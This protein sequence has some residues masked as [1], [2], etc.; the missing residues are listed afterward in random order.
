MD[1]GK[2]I[3]IDGQTNTQMEEKIEIKM[4][5]PMDGRTDRQIEG[6]PDGQT[7]T[8]T[9]IYLTHVYMILCAV[10]QNITLLTAVRPNAIRRI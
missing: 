5:E 3:Q 6:W 9:Y 1:Q 10:R 4:N 8:L 7:K 2:D